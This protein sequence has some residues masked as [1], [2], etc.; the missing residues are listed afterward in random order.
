MKK[1]PL[2]LLIMRISVLQ[3][4]LILSLIGS[5]VAR[6][7]KAQGLLDKKITLNESN[8][9]LENVL[10]QIEK[11]GDFSFVYKT[12]LTSSDKTISI[13]A[14]NQSLSKVLDRV[15]APFNLLYEVSNNYIVI[16]PAEKVNNDATVITIKGTVND[17]QG[18]P[19]PGVTIKAKGGPAV[20][21][22]DMNG[23]Y[24]IRVID[25]NSVLVFSFI[26]FI[27]QEIALNNRTTV[28][29]VLK[30][31]T[32]NLSEVVVIGYGDQAKKNLST[33]ISSIKAADVNELP[34]ASLSDALAG[35][36]AGVD[37]TS[38]FGGQP[39]VAADITIRGLGSLGSS[40]SPLYVVDGYPLESADQFSAINP[41]DIASIDILKDAAS[42][43]IY[44][45]RASNGVVIVTTKRGKA[46][47]TKFT[48]STYTGVQQLAH[49][50]SLM[51][52][53]QYIHQETLLNGQRAGK[54][55][56]TSPNPNFGNTDWQNQLYKNAWMTTSNM[57][58]SGGTENVQYN[59][60]ASYLNQ[61]GV[62]IT[63]SFKRYSLRFNLDAKLSDKLKIGIN[64]SPNFSVQYAVPSGGNFTAT[65]D[66]SYGSSGAIPNVIYSALLMPPIVPK[67][68]PD[69]R[70]GQPDFFPASLNMSGV[71]VENPVA[72]LNSVSN[73]NHNFQVL[74]NA[75]LQ[76]SILKDLTYKLNAGGNIASNLNNAYVSDITPT[77][78]AT[79]ASYLSPNPNSIYAGETT[80]R[81]TD[82]LAENT[83]TYN[84]NFKD[85]HHLNVLLLQS[86][87]KF[88]STQDQVNGTT[89]TYTSDAIQN[90]SASALALGS[91]AYDVYTYVSYAARINYDYKEKYLFS[92]SIREDG[93]SK[94]GA[95]NRFGTFRSISGAWRAGEEK[96]IQKIDWISEL[97]LRASYGE[98]GNANIGS[99]TWLNNIITSNYN[100][101][102]TGSSTGV[103]NF[104]T[105]PSGYYNPDLT[106]EKNHQLDL[107]FEIGVLKDRIYFTADVYRKET[108][109]MIQSK[110][111][112]GDVGYAQTYK[113]NT[114]DLLNKGLE[115]AL[116]TINVKS[117]NFSWTTNFNIAFNRNK[118]L[119]LGGPQA[120]TSS[121]AITGWSNV[122]QITVG[123]PIGDIYGYKVN[124]ILHDAAEVA[125]APKFDSYQAQPGDMRYVDINHDGTIS[126]ADRTVLGNAMPKF[127]GG[128][129]NTFK[130]KA[131]DLSFVLTGR[132]GGSIVN[133]NLR[134]AFGSAGFN[135]PTQFLD[136]MYLT[137]NPEANVKYPNVVLS[138][139]YSFVSALTSLDVEDAS[140][141]RMRNI[142]AGYTFTPQILRRIKLQ[143]LRL[144]VAGQNVFTL[145]KYSGYNPEVSVNGNSV[146]APGIDQG[147][148][149]ATRNFIVGI[150][151]GF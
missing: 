93:S 123:Q 127:T 132:Y 121:A 109:D 66:N 125:A 12:D 8:V 100:F 145:T 131:F 114:G 56:L 67:Y 6:N 147:V 139:A 107:G 110:T 18:Q 126:V 91:V 99:F 101:G 88:N 4:S 106:W 95:D 61:D 144:Y 29:V 65:N 138:G 33:S 118:V 32:K 51:D 130:Y 49:K 48:F 16:K 104:G 82:W 103:R 23:K 135:M 40:N 149:P 134:N 128:M 14:D 13:N 54:L 43:S 143:T 10:D 52:S 17:E 34:V 7:G 92:T 35:K 31:D 28:D 53:A 122:F 11:L 108:Y 120:L 74:G 133:G 25:A 70:Y 119:S 116:T 140:Y 22:T 30:A 76:W 19:V 39:G 68:M 105:D 44:G 20:T 97:K 55:V 80:Y 84:H 77:Q 98:T 3:L 45:S 60:S 137:S 151:V 129:T 78:F 142:T 2:L 37:V 90:P 57:T 59:L 72:V 136:N 79:L 87:Q 64:I 27:T 83:L 89:G 146:T 148:Y 102:A 81:S 41:A 73:I 62:E 9:K 1:K 50:I 38:S 24:S 113:T 115:M 36:A 150:N 63:S 47:K 69:G 86:A 124:G 5:A 21:T 46:G 58:A 75:Y 96:F 94:F 112:L 85:V 71:N 42:A 15:L 141:L 117:S 26:G 111:L